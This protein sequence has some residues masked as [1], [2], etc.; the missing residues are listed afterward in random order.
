MLLAMW[1]E[2]LREQ[3]QTSNTCN[4]ALL[5]IDSGIVPI[6]PGHPFSLSSRSVGIPSCPSNSSRT[7]PSILDWPSR[8]TR[9]S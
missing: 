6:T 5:A 8:M 3:P 2:P 7:F 4:W 1:N 9:C